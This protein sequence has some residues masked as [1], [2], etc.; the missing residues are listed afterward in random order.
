M[1]VETGLVKVDWGSGVGL[2]SQ[3]A[4]S[5]VSPFVDGKTIVSA[6]QDADQEAQ[7]EQEKERAMAR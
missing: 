1:L 3:F 2:Q 4:D 7:A 6:D 5:G